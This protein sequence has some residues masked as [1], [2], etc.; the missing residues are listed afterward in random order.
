[1]QGDN[2]VATVWSFTNS[3]T[4]CIFEPFC[5]LQDLDDL[6]TNPCGLN[7]V[8]QTYP[9]SPVAF[10]LNAR[11]TTSLDQLPTDCLSMMAGGTDQLK[12]IQ[13]DSYPHSFAESWTS[14]LS[15]DNGSSLTEY[16]VCSDTEWEHSGWVHKYT[17]GPVQTW[18]ILVNFC[19]LQPAQVQITVNRTGVT[20]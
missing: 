10:A 2:C 18:L 4:R 20:S 7:G 8:Q 19:P 11:P 9:L 5:L 1:M 6:L 17:V 15:N 16:H 3:S 14:V 13:F 12:V